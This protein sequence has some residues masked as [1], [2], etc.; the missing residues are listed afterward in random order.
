[1]LMSRAKG[2]LTF[3]TSLAHEGA[4]GGWL[5]TTPQ[6]SSLI[7]G[8]P[9]PSLVAIVTGII[10]AVVFRHTKRLSSANILEHPL[11]DHGLGNSIHYTRALSSALRGRWWVGTRRVERVSS[12]IGIECVES[13]VRVSGELVLMP[14]L[15]TMTSTST[16][17]GDIVLGQGRKA[18]TLRGFGGRG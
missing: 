4:S 5:L 17:S 9:N 14:I 7:R 12:I 16:R 18:R 2:S 10:L 3:S 11:A 8:E 6:N 1:M 13:V 15:T